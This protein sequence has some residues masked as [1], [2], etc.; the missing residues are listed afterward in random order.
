MIKIVQNHFTINEIELI[1][2]YFFSFVELA[3]N[4]CAINYF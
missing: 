4:I 2:G 1:F 3:L